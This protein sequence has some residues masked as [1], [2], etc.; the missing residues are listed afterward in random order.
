MSA[1]LLLAAC[2]TVEPGGDPQ[3]AQVVYEEDYFYCQVLP[4]VIVA[5]SCGS[6]DP[7]QDTAG[8]CHASATSFR[9]V[10]LSGDVPCT[11]NRRSG[12]L[13]QGASENYTA[14]QSEMTQD[15]DTAPLLAHPT[16]K[17]GHPRQIFATQSPEADI[18]RQWAQRSS[19]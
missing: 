12:A 18:I 2:S 13:P 11:G 9:V 7:T 19:R 10:P 14:A 3:I 8:G 5:Q 1:A 16:K 15:P 4:N 17:A 6:G